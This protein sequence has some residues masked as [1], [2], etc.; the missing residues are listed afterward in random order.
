MENCEIKL[1][2]SIDNSIISKNSKILQK[3]N[4]NSKNIFL[5]GEG[6]KIYL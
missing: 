6:T 4:I 2:L 5:L 3:Q 1:E